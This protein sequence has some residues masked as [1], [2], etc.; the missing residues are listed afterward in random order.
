MKSEVF[1][2]SCIAGMPTDRT[3]ETPV[4]TVTVYLPDGVRQSN[5]SPQG[6]AELLAHAV[7]DVEIT[8]DSAYRLCY[9]TIELTEVDLSDYEYATPNLQSAD[10]SKVWRN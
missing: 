7:L 6:K 1:R 8:N 4:K 2:I 10:G 9:W 3:A 5:P